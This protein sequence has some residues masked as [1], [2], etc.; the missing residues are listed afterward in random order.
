MFVRAQAGKNGI[1]CGF[2]WFNKKAFSLTVRPLSPRGA[3][4]WLC[5]SVAKK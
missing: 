2:I 5:V 1:K 4:F 3:Y